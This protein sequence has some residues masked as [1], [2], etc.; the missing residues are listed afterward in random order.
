M[1]HHWLQGY[2]SAGPLQAAL[3]RATSVEQWQHAVA[4]QELYDPHDACSVAALR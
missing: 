3:L 1:R 4:Q 2:Q